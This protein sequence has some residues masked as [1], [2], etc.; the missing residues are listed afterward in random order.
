MSRPILLLLLVSL[1]CATV[2]TAFRLDGRQRCLCTTA[3]KVNPRNIKDWKVHRPSA[4][5]RN[6][7]IVVTLRNQKKVCLHRNTKIWQLIMQKEL[8]SV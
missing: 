4:Y 5:C 2:C 1:V 8:G 6:T 7:E 3:H